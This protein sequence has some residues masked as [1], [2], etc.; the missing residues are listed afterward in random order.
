MR[1]DSLLKAVGCREYE[2]LQ[3]LDHPN[4]V[5]YYDLIETDYPDDNDRKE[6][7]D[8]LHKDVDASSVTSSPASLA[9]F[10]SPSLKDGKL[11]LVMEWLGRGC[12]L[13]HWIRT[14]AGHEDRVKYL[15]TVQVILKQLLAAIVHLRLCNISHHDIKLENVIFDGEKL[16]LIDFGVAEACP[17]DASFCPY[18]TPAYQPPE[19]V[20]R[21]DPAIPI[22][23]HKA[24][25]WS[26][27]VV[28]Y[29]L[30]R[31]DGTLPFEADSIYGVFDRIVHAEP[32]YSAIREPAL[33][34]FLSRMDALCHIP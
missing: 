31:D 27:G 22:S 23:G 10:H 7:N 3:T 6:S 26:F 15:R 20:L 30:A 17:E 32:D 19:L 24:D 34:D 18:G 21:S 12:N 4:I 8:A 5:R 13:H 16:T 25:M 29:Q 1:S 14:H 28:A 9:S 11:Y 2:L 33:R